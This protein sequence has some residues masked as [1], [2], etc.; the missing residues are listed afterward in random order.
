M[1]KQELHGGWYLRTLTVEVAGTLNVLLKKIGQ[2]MMRAK[3]AERK[4]RKRSK[5]HATM[6]LAEI[7]IEIAH[8][9]KIKAELENIRKD[10]PSECTSQ[11]YNGLLYNK[12]RL[13]AIESGLALFEFFKDKKD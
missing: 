1:V 9:T 7:K 5:R 2:M 13:G 11:A 4:E 12:A 6:R 3:L 10:M 8:L